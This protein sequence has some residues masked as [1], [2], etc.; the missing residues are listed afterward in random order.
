MQLCVSLRSRR[1]CVDRESVSICIHPRL[2][3]AFPGA[4]GPTDPHTD[5][6]DLAA[7][8][9]RGV[10]IYGVCPASLRRVSG[11]TPV[12]GAGKIGGCEPGVLKAPERFLIGH[13]MGDLAKGP[14]AL[15]LNALL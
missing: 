3:S 11:E 7:R 14:A 9:G 13:G 10:F 12:R 4:G 6:F 2:P 1:L 5:I 8:L 15:E